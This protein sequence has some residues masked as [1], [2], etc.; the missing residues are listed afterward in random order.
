M[1]TH[2]VC[3]NSLGAVAVGTVGKDSHDAQDYSLFAATL[4]NVYAKPR[5]R[6]VAYA[7]MA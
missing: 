1:P 5:T 3:G 2:R 4:H 6:H 7:I